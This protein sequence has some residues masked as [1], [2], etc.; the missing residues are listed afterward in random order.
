MSGAAHSFL[1]VA[2]SPL[3]AF[4]YLLMRD[5]LPTGK[6]R[7]LIEE[8]TAVGEEWTPSASEL[9]ELAIRYGHDL[10]GIEA[11]KDWD[12]PAPPP[13]PAPPEP[14]PDP[15]ASAEQRYRTAS[16]A[17]RGVLDANPGRWM[18]L[19]EMWALT[20]GE[21][22]CSFTSFRQAAQRLVRDGA[23]EARGATAARQYRATQE[24]SGA[25]GSAETSPPES[26]PDGVG[27]GDPADDNDSST[28]GKSPAP[29]S[30]DLA[31]EQNREHDREHSSKHTSGGEVGSDQ[32]TGS[33][34]DGEGEAPTGLP[35]SSS[36][37]KPSGR[38]HSAAAVQRG[39][40]LL[41]ASPAVAD[42][43]LDL[44]VRR[45]PRPATEPRVN[46]SDETRAAVEAWV[47]G[48]QTFRKRQ[49]ADAFPDFDPQVLHLALVACG[50]A[51]LV[52]LNT[53]EAGGP[54]YEVTSN[55]A[56]HDQARPTND[57]AGTLEGRI[58]QYLEGTGGATLGSTSA[59]VGAG[60]SDCAAALSK[61]VRENNLRWET[62]GNERFYVPA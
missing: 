20:G 34:A 56:A 53:G 61:L 39:A 32:Q 52:V 13:A 47:R 8:A 48:Q 18:K 35:A 3:I 2:T 51:G 17:V 57:A 40:P 7:A 46:L 19:R 43:P 55:A 14:D 21:E 26:S 29:S 62:R 54:F 27:D 58:L 36:P 24:V 12:V 23:A 4:L 6:V 22:A 10:I 30:A 16:D 9:N 25:S 5:E 1:G 50:E 42:P 44:H 38:R 59:H 33:S 49:V 45:R 15:P 41:P 31:D 11:S 28:D 60:Q 37:A